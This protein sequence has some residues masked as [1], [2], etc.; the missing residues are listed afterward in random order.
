MNCLVCSSL[1]EKTLSFSTFIYPPQQTL[2]CESCYKQ[3]EP[4]Q[5]KRCLHCSN[6]CNESLCL[7]CL[8][9]QQL[10][11]KLDTLDSNY[12]IYPYTP[13][14]KTVFAK[15]KYRGD[16]EL[17]RIFKP[18]IQEVSQKHLMVDPSTIIIPIPLSPERLH[19]RAFNQAEMI[20]QWISP[21][22]DTSLIIRKNHEK[23]AKK[24]KYERIN[25]ENPFVLSNAIN[26]PVLLV[27]DIYTTG[28]TLR[29]ASTILK[30]NGCPRV[31]AFTLIR[32]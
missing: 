28:A 32:S 24:S 5:G 10:R 18:K 26:N 27:D 21:Q 15:W 8:E 9:W 30:E 20:A 11:P 22:V 6:V 3:L 4:I 2:I 25:S 1:I 7:D 16:Y 29:H 17:G 12:A 19:V 31:D 14:I 23:Q 13:F